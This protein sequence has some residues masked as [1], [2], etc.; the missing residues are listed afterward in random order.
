LFWRGPRLAIEAR[1]HQHRDSSGLWP[2]H[3]I[4][5]ADDGNRREA[6]APPHQSSVVRA[7]DVVMRPC[8][9][10]SRRGP[11]H[12]ARMVAPLAF[13]A[14]GAAGTAHAGPLQIDPRTLTG[15][16]VTPAMD[17]VLGRQLLRL[18]VQCDADAMVGT[19]EKPLA[20]DL[21]AD[22][23]SFRVT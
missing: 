17:V 11:R 23:A 13:V 7:F 15:P 22:A 9:H 14:R 18:G 19:V 12:R 6:R 10:V 4:C 2:W 8:D 20:W 3:P 1:A 16:L 5:T 21:T